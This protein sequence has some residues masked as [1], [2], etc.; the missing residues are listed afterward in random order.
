MN[1]NASTEISVAVRFVRASA[2]AALVLGLSS[3]GCAGTEDQRKAG[4]PRA[5]TAESGE[6]PTTRPTARSK[7]ATQKLMRHPWEKKA[8]AA[9]GQ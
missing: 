4:A 5:S 8:L 6:A 3:P 1:K 2:L 9:R 7:V